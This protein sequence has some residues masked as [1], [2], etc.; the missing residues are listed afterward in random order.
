MSDNADWRLAAVNSI[1]D[2]HQKGEKPTPNFTQL[3]LAV[4]VLQTM[5]TQPQLSETYD[6]ILFVMER[7]FSL[8]H[9][10]SSLH[11]K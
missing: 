6:R 1:L 9:K 10:L 2:A 5:H 8:P 7:T 11:A 3:Q 4:Q